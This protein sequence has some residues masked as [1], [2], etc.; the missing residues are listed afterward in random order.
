MAR[1]SDSKF[2]ENSLF[3]EQLVCSLSQFKD[4]HGS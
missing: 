1:A 2:D 4:P 3:M